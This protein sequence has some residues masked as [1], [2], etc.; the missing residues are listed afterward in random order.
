[1]VSSIVVNSDISFEFH[2]ISE[3]TV[4][5]FFGLLSVGA[6]ITSFAILMDKIVGEAR[7]FVSFNGIILYIG[8][9]VL[10]S[11]LLFGTLLHFSYIDSALAMLAIM[12]IIVMKNYRFLDFQ[13]SLYMYISVLVLSLIE[14][15]FFN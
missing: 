10:L 2:R 4:L 11:T 15:Y 12:M 3:I 13:Q 9:A 6:T 14:A 8:S 1:M 7:Q 5:S